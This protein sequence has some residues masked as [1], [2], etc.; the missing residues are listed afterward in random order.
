MFS[1]RIANAIIDAA[2]A[3]G[4]QPAALLAIVEVETGGKTFEQDG[5]TPQFL[6][7]RHVAWREA[8][9]F[10]DNVLTAFRRAGLAI[11]H[12]ARSTQYRDERTSALRLALIDRAKQLSQEVACRSASWGLGQT[13]GNLAEELGFP[14]ATAMVEHQTGSVPGQIDC[15]VR[16]LKHTNLVHSLNEHDW[17]RVARVYNGPGYAA[18]QYDVKLRD[19]FT[20]WSRKL[21]RPA[22]PPAPEDDLAH[23]EIKTIQQDL[24]DLGYFEVGTPDGH[25]GSRTAGAVSAFQTHEGLHVNGHLDEDTLRAIKAA[26]LPRPISGERAD[27]TADDLRDAGS[28]TVAHADSLASLGTAKKAAGGL[29][30]GGGVLEQTDLLGKATDAVDKVEQ[31]KSVY[32]R[33]HDFAHPFLSSP[34]VIVF[35]VVLLV[36]GIVVGAIAKRIIKNRLKDHRTGEHA[37]PTGE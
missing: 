22:D 13:M 21:L 30:V 36:A 16:E 10:G 27:A 32:E 24:R 5:R 19:A 3:N 8:K 31:A 6:Y 2:N 18:N 20:R 17:R 7:E 28:E 12:W 4:I 1:D 25:W 11:P 15:M 29:L 23:D 9:R 34:S 35:G 26:E 37:G 14:H 33:V